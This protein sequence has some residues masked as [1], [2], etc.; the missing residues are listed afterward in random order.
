VV[1][2]SGLPRLYDVF[3][4]DLYTIKPKAIFTAALN[5]HTEWWTCSEVTAET[6]IAP[7]RALP[8]AWF[9]VKLLCAGL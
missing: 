8:S 7:P 5:T 3:H 6:L 9:A 1:T 2:C 4:I